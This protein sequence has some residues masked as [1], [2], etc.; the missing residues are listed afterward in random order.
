MTIK[1]LFLAIL[2]LSILLLMSGCKSSDYKQAVSLFDSGEYEKAQKAFEELGEYKDSKEYLERANAEISYTNAVSLFDSG[3]YEK[4]QKNFEEL[5]EYKDSKEYLEKANAIITE[6]RYNHALE[7]FEAEDYSKA[8]SAFSSLNDYKDSLQ[9]MNKSKEMLEKAEKAKS[10]DES[11]QSQMVNAAYN[12]LYD[13]MSREQQSMYRDGR[14]NYGSLFEWSVKQYSYDEKTHFFSG[15]VKITYIMD[16]RSLGPVKDSKTVEITGNYSENT[17]SI[18]ID[19]ITGY[20][21]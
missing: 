16:A 3:E 8:L 14:Q 10:R 17:D 7:L 13:S 9:Y 12:K 2:T 5:G 1:K 18:E 11:I 20:R 4:A 15:T 19:T 6:E 21:Y